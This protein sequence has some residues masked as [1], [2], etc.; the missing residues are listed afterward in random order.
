MNDENEQDKF[1]CDAETHQGR[2]RFSTAAD[3]Q[4]TVY[5]DEEAVI[6]VEHLGTR[7]GK[8]FACEKHRA[9]LAEWILRGGSD[10]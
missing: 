5:C 4:E 9:A 6:A 3:Y 8:T 10:E 2:V 1:E 7:P